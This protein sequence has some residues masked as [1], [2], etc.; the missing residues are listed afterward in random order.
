MDGPKRARGTGHLLNFLLTRL[1]NASALR[2]FVYNRRA[3]GSELFSPQK[4][5]VFVLEISEALFC[6]AKRSGKMRHPVVFV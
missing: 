1:P 3:R 5:L 6:G 2:N 4:N